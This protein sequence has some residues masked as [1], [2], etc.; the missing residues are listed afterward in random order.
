MNMFSAP[1]GYPSEVNV[2]ARQTPRRWGSNFRFAVGTKNRPPVWSILSRE[3]LIN[4]FLPQ[5]RG[6]AGGNHT[7]RTPTQAGSVR[8]NHRQQTQE[9]SNDDQSIGHR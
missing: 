1:R 6:T 4:L 8:A 5:Y 3:T 9:K 2:T 7:R